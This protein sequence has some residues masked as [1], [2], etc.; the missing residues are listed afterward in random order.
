MAGAVSR[1]RRSKGIAVGALGGQ[2]IRQQRGSA[3][4]QPGCCG[5]RVSQRPGRERIGQDHVAAP[6][7]RI[8][9][10]R[11]RGNLDGGRTARSAPSIQA[12]SQHR[13]SELRLFP[14][15]SVF[16][17][18]AYGLRVK[19]V[20][21]VE[22]KGR[23]G[24]GVGDGEDVEL[25]RF[26]SGEDQ[27]RAATACRTGTGVGE[28]SQVT[29]A[30][31]AAIGAGC[32]PATANAGRTQGSATRGWNRVRLCHPRSGRGDDHVGPHCAA[33]LRGNWSRLRRPAKS[34]AGL[35]PHIRHSSSGKRTCC[36]LMSPQVWQSVQACAGP[37]ASPMVP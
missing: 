34:T 1:S 21:A 7:R 11:Q 33:S 15:L 35:Q 22:V 31:R 16:D 8:R 18:V 2:A 12:A 13:V 25:R 28:P 6:N 9:A 20:P 36:T 27:R 4:H 37:P 24:T 14:H 10:L 30:G 29:V 23:V 5:G 26:Q 19:N 3:Q 17:N 32:Q